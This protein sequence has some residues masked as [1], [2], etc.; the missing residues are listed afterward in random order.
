VELDKLL[1]LFEQRLQVILKTLIKMCLAK[2]D[3]KLSAEY[4]QMYSVTLRPA[5]TL[6]I[7][8]LAEHLKATLQKV[9]AIEQKI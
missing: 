1:V 6:E 5:K 4:K 7:K 3:D 8:Q 2:K 9:K